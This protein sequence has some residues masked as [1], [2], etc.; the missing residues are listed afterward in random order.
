MLF[1]ETQAGEIDFETK[2]KKGVYAPARAGY[3][4]CASRDVLLALTGP[5]EVKRSQDGVPRPVLLRL[6]PESSFTDITYLTKQVFAF[7]CHSW[8]NLPTSLSASNDS[9]LESN[10]AGPREPRL[11]SPMGPRRDVGPCRTYKVV[12]MT[13]AADILLADGRALLLKEISASPR[14][15]LM[16]GF[17]AWLGI[18][19]ED[20]LGGTRH[21]CCGKRRPPADISGCGASW[22]CGA[23]RLS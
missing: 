17:C 6:H 22:I 23:C 2:S 5:R 14:N 1:D 15:E 13:P 19:D 21:C 16:A 7:S 11:T 4:Q 3:S 20:T 10:C 8:A 9:I 18:A 12:L